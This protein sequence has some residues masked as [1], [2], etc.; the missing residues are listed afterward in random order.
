M[1]SQIGKAQLLLS[2]QKFLEAAN[3][4]LELL[5]KYPKKVEAFDL[6][7]ECSNALEHFKYTKGLSSAQSADLE[8]LHAKIMRKFRS[9]IVY[10]L[11]FFSFLGLMPVRPKEVR[12]WMDPIDDDTLTEKVRATVITEFM[13][14]FHTI[15]RL[16]TEDKTKWT[17]SFDA[18]D[19][20]D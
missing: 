8:K 1:E 6:V 10:K 18:I 15:S 14:Q 9:N 19:A 16:R 5:Q 2:E 20:L 7:S 17:T 12:K 3:S 4:A 11:K 13:A